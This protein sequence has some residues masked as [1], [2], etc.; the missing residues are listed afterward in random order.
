MECFMSRILS[1]YI[2]VLC[3]SFVLISC[4]NNSGNSNLNPKPVFQIDKITAGDRN[5]RLEWIVSEGYSY[6]LYY[7]NNKNVSSNNA[8]LIEIKNPQKVLIEG[9]SKS[10]AYFDHPVENNSFYYYVLVKVD[11]SGNEQAVSQTVAAYPNRTLLTDKNTFSDT[12]LHSCVLEAAVNNNQSSQNKWEYLSDVDFLNCRGNLTSL[13]GLE[14]LTNLNHITYS[15]AD[16]FDFTDSVYLYLSNLRSLFLSNIVTL[17]INGDILSK[18]ALLD[19]ISIH[20]SGMNNFN[21][22]NNSYNNIS[23]LSLS[24]VTISDNTISNINK[25]H[26]PKLQQIDLSNSGRTNLN[27]LKTANLDF[28]RSITI[29]NEPNLI[30][31]SGIN[32]FTSP[33][34]SSLTLDNIPMLNLDWLINA[35]LKKIS[36][37]R[38]VNVGLLSLAGIEQVKFTSD[39]LSLDFSRNKLTQLDE[40]FSS[41]INIFTL[42]VRNNQIS[43]INGIASVAENLVVLDLYGNNLSDF[44]GFQESLFPE[45]SSLVLG[46]NNFTTMTG[47]DVK[48]GLSTLKKYP[49]LISLYLASGYGSSNSIV[50]ISDYTGVANADLDSLFYLSLDGRAITNFDSLSGANLN[51]LQSLTFNDSTLRSLSSFSGFDQMGLSNLVSL[52]IPLV[53]STVSFNGLISAKLLK[54]RHL[55]ITSDLGISDLSWFKAANLTSLESLL[56]SITNI[57]DINWMD[58][59]QMQLLS[60]LL[61]KNTASQQVPLNNDYSSLGMTLSQLPKLKELWIGYNYLNSMRTMNDLT[62]LDQNAGFQS[63]EKLTL[64]R[65]GLK[66][67]QGITSQNMP[68]LRRLG[69][70]YNDLTGT[71]ELA[72]SGLINLEYINLI[73]NNFN[74][75]DSV[76]PLSY[77]TKSKKIKILP[78]T[79]ISN[80]SCNDLSLLITV[81]GS[82]VLDIESA[83]S[84]SNCV[85]P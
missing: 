43:N 15:D 41:N 63:L 61:I 70:S 80:V 28:L 62:W 47:F 83:D 50:A 6:N 13:L 21:W 12:N 48:P 53:D 64:L 37:L 54:L 77:F 68:K 34:L 71:I 52:S 58:P 8:T 36:R 57:N 75:T 38:L 44:S 69:L 82:A 72:S 3:L 17:N 20:N 27:W 67:S 24:D 59:N 19:D 5:V 73:R 14:K 32:G 40:L 49:K 35:D 79:G 51:S 9:T 18:V 29:S 30:D 26:F 84:T 16:N 2:F 33:S 65:L 7:S 31:L 10:Y 11:S 85:L 81:L 74:G 78:T 66:S 4:S 23:S 1:Q 76:L 22:L 45:L 39:Y 55:D 46:G 60:Y 56:L 42:T 25:S